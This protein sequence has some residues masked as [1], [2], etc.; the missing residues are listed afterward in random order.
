MTLTFDKLQVNPDKL[1]AGFS[2]DIYATDVALELVAGGMSFRD[3]YKEVG[4]NLDKLGQLDPD[5]SIG[6]RTYP[7]TTGNLALDQVKVRLDYILKETEKR[8]EAIGLAVTSLMG[9]PVQILL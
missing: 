6:S 4:L 1:K 5:D 9:E 2:K 8:E 7:G 3:A